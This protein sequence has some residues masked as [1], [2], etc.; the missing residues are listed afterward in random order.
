VEEGYAAQFFNSAAVLRDGE[1][2]FV[3]RKLNLAT[4]GMLEE[5][6]FFATGRYVEPFRVKEHYAASLLIC[7]DMWNPALVHL[8]ALHGCTLLL[9]PINS[10]ADSVSGAFSNPH[11]WQTVLSFY[12]MIYGLPIVMANRIGQEGGLRFWG[13]TRI[14]DAFGN[15]LGAAALQ[16]EDLIVAD[17]DYGDVRRA[18]FQLP[19]VRD[20]NLDLVHREVNRLAER[21]GVPAALRQ[22]RAAEPAPPA[23]GS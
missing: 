3:H 13:G 5:A 17:L 10:A 21:I 18:R 9:A 22:R 12:A 16:G 8:A 7:A 15:E 23:G 11:G 1:V 2:A 6:K 14:L 20:S 4:Y 19:T